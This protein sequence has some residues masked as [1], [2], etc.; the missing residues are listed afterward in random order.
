MSI[1]KV[2]LI[3]GCP[4]AGKTTLGRAIAGKLGY[5]SLTIDDL[6]NAARAVTTS[7][8]HPG[9]HVTNKPNFVDYFTNSPV[10]QLIADATL[11]H[12]AIWPAVERT[13]RNHATWGTPIVIDGFHL[14]PEWTRDLHIDNV[15]AHWL[16][17]DAAVL[18]ERERR[19]TE[20]FGSSS[21]PQQMFERFLARS[22]WC[23]DLVATQA[24]STG[25]QV[26][27]QDGSRAVD[28][29]CRLIEAQLASPPK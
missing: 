11:Q 8:S 26:L 14:R 7:Q 21:N 19:N 2:V 13:I 20:F 12:Q 17:V 28:H 5:A 3:G 10:E 24:A 1:P 18:E 27:R 22:L 6:V 29:L 16:V 4:G 15:S 23:N 25:D 9:L